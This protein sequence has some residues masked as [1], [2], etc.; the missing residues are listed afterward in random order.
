MLLWYVSLPLEKPLTNLGQIN[1]QSAPHYTAY[2]QIS[3]LYP[4]AFDKLRSQFNSDEKET[5]K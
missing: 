3:S 4:K 2:L 5:K 1:V